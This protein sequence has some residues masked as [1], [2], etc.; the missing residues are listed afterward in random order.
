V[1]GTAGE[2]AARLRADVAEME[3]RLAVLLAG[4]D[5][6]GGSDG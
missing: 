6:K 4:R 1:H 2:Y 3:T 5:E